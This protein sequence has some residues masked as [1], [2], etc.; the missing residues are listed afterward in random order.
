MKFKG[1][2]FLNFRFDDADVQEQIKNGTLWEHLKKYDPLDY[3]M[4]ASTPGEDVW[5]EFGTKPKKEGSTGLVAGHAY[6]LIMV[7]SF[8]YYLFPPPNR[9][10]I[11]LEG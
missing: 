2:P 3:I 11:F 5:T 7:Y 6:T 9:G 10:N 4:S 1:A 8:P